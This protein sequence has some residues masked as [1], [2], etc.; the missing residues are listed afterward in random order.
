M[1]EERFRTISVFLGVFLLCVLAAPVFGGQGTGK[2]YIAQLEV[3]ENIPPTGE[4]DNFADDLWLDESYEEVYD[5][6][7]PLNRVFFH[8][9]DRLYF[10]VLKPV[11]TVYAKAL[12]RDIRGCIRNAFDNLLAPVRIV[13]N[14]LQGKVRQSGVEVVR[15]A[16][17]STIGIGGMV[18]SARSD[19]GLG[20]S[21]EDFGQT[22]AVYGLGSGPYITW[23]LLGPSNFRDTV[24]LVGDGFLDPLVYLTAGSLSAKIGAYGGKRLNQ[25]SLTL[26]DYELFTETSLDPYA[27]IRDAYQQFRQGRI[28]DKEGGGDDYL[29]SAT[30]KKAVREAW[31]YDFEFPLE[32]HESEILNLIISRNI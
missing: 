19:F 30:G 31:A 6:L 24:G 25:V 32:K 28:M 4:S 2:I 11:A 29:N 16:I 8:F 23:P 9:N 27:A 17:N 7:E 15:F 10:W 14:L 26:G 1:D 13:N 12:P 22:L 5:P 20:P 18:D 3:S 21:E